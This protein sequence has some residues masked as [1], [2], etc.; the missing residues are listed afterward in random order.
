LLGSASQHYYMCWGCFFFLVAALV[1]SLLHR[2]ARNLLHAAAL[3][4]ITACG[5]TLNLLP[6]LLYWWHFGPNR[7]CSAKLPQWSEQYGLKLAAMLLPISGHRLQALR[8]LRAHYDATTPVP[9][10][11]ASCAIGSIAA[12]GFLILIALL[13]VPRM[14]QPTSSLRRLSWLNLAAVLLATLGGFGTLFSYLVNPQLHGYERMSIYIALFG[15]AAAACAV[16]GLARR[17]TSGLV[18]QGVVLGGGALALLVG[19]YDQTTRE[20]VPNYQ[21]QREQFQRYEAFG[22]AIEQAVPPGTMVFQLPLALFP[23]E[24][25]LIGRDHLQPYLHTRGLRWSY[26]AMLNRPAAAWQ[27]EVSS[28]PL[29][30]MLEVLAVA[31]FGAVMVDIRGNR[32]ENVALAHQLRQSLQVEPILDGSTRCFFSLAGLAQSLKQ[33][34]TPE[35]WEQRRQRMLRPSGLVWGPGLDIQETG[36]SSPWRKWRWCTNPSGTIELVNDEREPLEVDVGMTV[37]PAGQPGSVIFSG[38]LLSCSA[39]LTGNGFALNRTVRVPP[40]RHRITIACAVPPVTYPGRTLYF[41][42]EGLSVSP[43]GKGDWLSWR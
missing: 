14:Q 34:Y 8:T 39:P 9:G 37:F 6:N 10:W 32:P 22:R 41:R 12:L 43:H 40:G 30:Q 21:E 13:F 19:L 5:F 28:L 7:D 17:A 2:Q 24:D 18:R 16:D 26:G 4:A 3:W 23:F 29:P 31:G 1:G 35:E 38:D 25:A 36:S 11:S 27:K 20:F 42:V 33:G 15:L